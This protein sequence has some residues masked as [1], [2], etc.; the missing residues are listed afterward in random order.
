MIPKKKDFTFQETVFLILTISYLLFSFFA[1]QLIGGHPGN[2]NVIIGLLALKLILGVALSIVLYYYYR[3]LLKSQWKKFRHHSWVKLLW[4]V[5]GWIGLLLVINMTRTVLHWTT[6]FQLRLW[7]LPSYM[8]SWGG[9]WWMRIFGTGLVFLNLLV[10]SFILEVVCR[11]LLFL[12]H[13]GSR[14]AM[15]LFGSLGIVLHGLAFYSYGDSL[16]TCLPYA[17][18]GGVLMFIYWQSRNIWYAITTHLLFNIVIF[19]LGLTNSFLLPYFS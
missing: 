7:N 15:V 14:G 4:V 18:S 10:L 9:S 19:I 16:Q 8:G 3:E 2:G 17:L 11:H 12:K 5:L 6:G 13:E 1:R